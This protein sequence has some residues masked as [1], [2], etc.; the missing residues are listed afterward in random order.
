MRQRGMSLIEMMIA[1]T[2]SLVVIGAVSGVYLSTSRSYTQDEL[3][4]RM[5]EN[6]R[7]ALHI[8]AEDLSMAGYF[9]PLMAGQDINTTAR[10]CTNTSTEEHCTGFFEG[11][12]LPALGTDCGPTGSTPPPYWAYSLALP[13]ETLPEVATRSE[14]NAA[15]SCIG[16]DD[17]EGFLSGADPGFDVASDILVVK[18]VEGAGLDSARNDEDDPGYIYLRTD[19]TYAML[20]SYDPD[21]NSSEGSNIKDWRYRSNIYYIRDYFLTD[22]NDNPADSIPTLVRKQLSGNSMSTEGG[23]IAQGIEYFHVMVGIDSDDPGDGTANYYTAS[24]APANM[25]NAVSARIY[26]L[27]RSVS[28]DPNYEN[29]KTYNLG[30]VS[31]TVD[32]NFYRRVFTTTV[33][34]RN[35]RNRIQTTGS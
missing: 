15:F 29:N 18:R 6:A 17:K 30:D 11:S 31:I 19:G 28:P 27:A 32:D 5:Q 7:F 33:T 25:R 20:F 22:D 21:L 16:T 8:L 14:A 26:V 34:L 1:M 9:G 13:I 24:P 12:T 23:G 10:T 3:I 35:Q 4:S 2:I